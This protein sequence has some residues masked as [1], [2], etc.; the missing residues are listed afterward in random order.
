MTFASLDFLLFFVIV[1]GVSAILERFFPVRFKEFFLLAASYFFY[2]YWD[3][4]FCFLLLFVTVA[5]FFAAKYAN[6]KPVYVAGIIVPLVVLGLFKYFN[7]FCPASVRFAGKS[8]AAC[9][10]FCR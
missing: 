1:L 8:W 3:W 4:R 2:G 9:A 7:L 10:L 6:R 5:A